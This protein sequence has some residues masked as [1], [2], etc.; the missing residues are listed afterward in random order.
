MP[1]EENNATPWP[2]DG[3]ERRAV[4]TL[5][6]NARNAR[7]HTG[8]QIE[9][10]AESIKLYGWT[11]PVLIDESGVILAGHGRVLAAQRLNIAE[12]PVIVARGWSGEKKR[13]YMLADNKLSLNSSWDKKM[14]SVELKELKDLSFDLKL[15][16]F[17]DGELQKLTGSEL[18]S[19]TKKG[20]RGSDKVE[21]G[22]IVQC[23]NEQDQ[24]TVLKNLSAQ[25]LTCRPSIL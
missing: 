1:D 8:A 4:A 24:A 11:M 16:G 13:A 20:S 17:K 9:Q 6:A 3:M 15:T 2:V 14:L 18:T 10:L 19:S 5:A 7:T 12:V 25:G 22:V 23:Q 21:Y